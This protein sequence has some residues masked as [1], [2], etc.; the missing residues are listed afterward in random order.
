MVSKTQGR[1]MIKSVVKYY[2]IVERNPHLLK[3]RLLSEQDITTKFV[4]PMLEALNW[5]RYKIT[6]EGP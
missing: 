2:G 4:L 6:E 1:A 5:N 3:D